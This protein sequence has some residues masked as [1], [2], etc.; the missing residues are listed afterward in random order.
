MKD[1]YRKWLELAVCVAAVFAAA[2]AGSLGMR[3]ADPTWYDDLTKPPWTPPD[4]LFGPVWSILYLLMAISVW[5]VWRARPLSG[6]AW[7]VA[8]FI[9]QLILNAVWTW[10]FF[11]LEN[12]RAALA[13]I[14]LL[15][16]AILATI[17]AF[18]RIRPLAATLLLPYLL[19]V[20]FAWTLNLTIWRMNP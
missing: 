2:A 7:P 9:A 16:L 13:D 15:W 20:S 17:T 18:S 1:A 14:S 5:L 3:L 12:P 19:W 11:K 10:L 8:I 6:R 4:G